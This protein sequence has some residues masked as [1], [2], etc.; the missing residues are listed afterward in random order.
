MGFT[1][2]TFRFLADLEANNSK[3]WFEV[4]RERYEKHWK[5]AALDVVAALAPSMAALEPALRAEPRLGGSL[6]RINRDVRFSADK[7]P[8]AATLHLIFWCGDHPNRAPGMHVVLNP[9]GVGFGAGQFGLDAAALDRLRRRIVDPADGDALVAAL[10]R[11]AAVGCTMGPPG[12]AR[13]PKGYAAEGRRGEVLRHKSIV[14]R[15]HG[16]EAPP[17]VVTGPEGLDW[18]LSTTEA[19]LPLIR[20]L[21]RP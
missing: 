5:D 4:N 1:R 10:D 15:T 3:A 14:A 16:T 11:A 20:W 6:R 9:C 2:E 21:T 19:L 7:T 12:L 8:Y 17:E 13:L 18:I